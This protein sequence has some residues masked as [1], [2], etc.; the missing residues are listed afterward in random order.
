MTEKSKRH[1]RTAKIGERLKAIFGANAKRRE[2]GADDVRIKVSPVMFIMAIVFV[3]QGRAYEFVCSLAAVILHECAHAR[4]A[5]K[6]GYELNEIKL[7]P[8]GAA[9]C[10]D[11][12]IYSRHEVLIALAGP[13]FNFALGMVFA[14]MWWLVPSSYAFTR[15]FCECNLYIGLFNLLPVYPLDGGRIIFCLLS[16]KLGTKRAYTVMR[17][18]SAVAGAAAVALFIASV[19]YSPNYCLLTV[20]IFMVVSA[21]VPDK[22]AKYKSLFGMLGSD[23]MKTRPLEVHTFAVGKGVKLS[24]LVSMLDPDAYSRFT[25]FDGGTEVGEI[26][27]G[28]LVEAVKLHGYDAVAETVLRAQ[29]LD[30]LRM[31]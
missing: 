15:A 13:L 30:F 22:R 24:K 9:L 29:T 5:K 7:M 18:I 1:R 28:E 31:K 6:L 26:D 23:K 20:G 11:E 21:F 2:R 8:Y 4:I 19:F 17:V 16:S 27:E 10:G 14:A 25:V 12:N 3:A